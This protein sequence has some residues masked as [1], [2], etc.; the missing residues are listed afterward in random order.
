MSSDAT[1]WVMVLGD[2]VAQARIVTLFNDVFESLGMRALA[3]PR[4]ALRIEPR[5]IAACLSLPQVVGVCTTTPVLVDAQT[6]LGTLS[7][8]ARQA[9]AISAV[10][11]D[12]SAPGHLYAELFDGIGFVRHLREHGFQPAGRSILIQ[13]AGAE[14]AALGFELARLGAARVDYRHWN[15][16]RAEQL[17]RRLTAQCGLHSSTH[18]QAVAAYDLVVFNSAAQGPGQLCE[19]E[20]FHA[21]MWVADTC[22]QSEASPVLQ[23]AAQC[24]ARTFTGIPFLR[25]QVRSYLSFFAPALLGTPECPWGILTASSTE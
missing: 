22:L 8:A 11:R 6:N 25:D 10:R 18:T 17:A 1:P 5:H 21:G 24:G 7:T 14:G 15:A 20:S 16:G 4:E 12:A 2:P 19:T 13:G 9:E 3:V 23:R